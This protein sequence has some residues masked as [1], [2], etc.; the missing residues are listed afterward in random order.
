MTT[1][2]W[3]MLMVTWGIILYFTGK[4][5]WM[6]LQ[7]PITPDREARTKDGILEKDA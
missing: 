4:F 3:L 2:A 7:T 5:F 1:A 6:V